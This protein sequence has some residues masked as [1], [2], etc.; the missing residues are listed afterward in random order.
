[1]I[2]EV[3]LDLEET[4]IDNWHDGQ[5]KYCNIIKIKSFLANLPKQPEHLNIW[6]HAIYDE[7]DKQ[8]FDKYMRESLERELGYLIKEFPSVKEQMQIAKEFENFKYDDMHEFMQFNGK[9]LSFMKMGFLKKDTTLY[10]I[11]DSAMS[12]S[13]HVHKNNVIMNLLNID[14]DF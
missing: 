8:H 13:I 9:N 4:I 14:T 3:W 7:A 5:F 6:S 2:V 10:L 1:M 11:D 12:I